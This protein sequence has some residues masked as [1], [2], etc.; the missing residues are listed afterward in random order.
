MQNRR[1]WKNEKKMPYNF[2]AF[3]KNVDYSIYNMYTYLQLNN[4]GSRPNNISQILQN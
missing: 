4:K 2:S 3:D 1:K